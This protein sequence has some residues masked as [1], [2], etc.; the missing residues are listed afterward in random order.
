MQWLKHP[1]FFTVDWTEQKINVFLLSSSEL[2]TPLDGPTT[3][4]PKLCIIMGMTSLDMMVGAVI[5]HPIGVETTSSD[6][7][8]F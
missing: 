2:Y 3:S 1:L 8:H 4:G 7:K 6:T 5:S